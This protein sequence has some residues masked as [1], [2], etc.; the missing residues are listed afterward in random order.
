VTQGTR[1]GDGARQHGAESLGAGRPIHGE[2]LVRLPLAGLPHAARRFAD[3]L[4]FDDVLTATGAVHVLG[5][6]DRALARVGTDSRTTTGEDLFV[7][8]SGERHD[9]NHFA[10]DALARGARALLLRGRPGDAASESLVADVRRAGG[11]DVSVALVADPLEALANL[12]A[13]RR[14]C[15]TGPVIGV[16][17]SSGKTSTKETL[18]TLLAR[19]LPVAKSPASFNNAI[20]VPRTILDA[21]PDARAL[22]L[23]LGTNAPGEIEGLCR[24]ARPTDGIVT[25]IGRAHLA[26]LGSE[27]G[28][29]HEKGALPAALPLGGVCVL[30]H[31]DRFRDALAARTAA[32]VVTFGE[33]DGADVVAAGAWLHQEGTS[34]L[35]RGPLVGAER[36]VTVPL[37]GAHA[38]RNVAAAL[39]LALARGFPLEQ[40]LTGLPLLEPVRGRMQRLVAGGVTFLDDSYNANPDSMRAGL[41]VLAGLPARKRVFVLGGMHELGASSDRLHREV[42][43][44]AASSVDVFVAIGELARPAALAARYA[45][46]DPARLHVAADIDDAVGALIALVAPGDVVLVK[47]SRA[48]R[49]ER[50]AEALIQRFSGAAPVSTCKGAER[51]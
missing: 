7:A 19:V 44:L 11:D 48:A 37:L 18:A 15:F 51:T 33:R 43:E 23:E 9:G 40:L 6:S 24:I 5:A 42:G 47:A 29:A 30:P 46:F 32:R 12:A 21:A 34:F 25:G 4:R 38:A 49:L 3:T 41:A 16:T 13:W 1:V 45:G 35:L 2:P 10:L 8:L 27:E 17:G 28:I 20:G 14:A 26:G 36:Q 22:V 50:V 31:D 39:A